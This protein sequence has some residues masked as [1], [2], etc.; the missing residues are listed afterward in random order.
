MKV[1]YEKSF[2]SDIKKVKN[3]K[4]LNNLTNTIEEIKSADEIFSLANIRKLKGHPAAYSIR[5]SDFRLGFF[6]DNNTAIITRFL[7][8]KDIYKFFP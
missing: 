7:N 2:L 8:R 1:L 3:K 5:I 4:L 6:Y